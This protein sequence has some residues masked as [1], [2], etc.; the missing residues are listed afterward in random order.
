M[1]IADIPQLIHV[2]SG[3]SWDLDGIV[4]TLDRFKENYGLDLDPDFQRGHVWEMET[5][6]KF[7]E[8]ILR[9]GVVQPIRF[10]SPAFGGHTHAKH[11][12]L[13][14]DVVL[15]DGKQRLTALMEFMENKFPVFGNV[16]LKDFDDPALLLRKTSISY[17]VNK[18]QTKRELCQWYLEMNEGQVAHT[19]AELDK[20]RKMIGEKT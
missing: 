2:N 11:S 17:Q 20:V 5:K 12:D 16:Y 10:N 9:G 13:P 8:Y 6:V 4:P 1:K 7:V 3:V 15:V 14:E 19:K 18:L